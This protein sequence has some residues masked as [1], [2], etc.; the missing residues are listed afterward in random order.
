MKLGKK[1]WSGWEVL[2]IGV[3]GGEKGEGESNPNTLWNY[4][5]RKLINEKAK[6]I[7]INT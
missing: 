4:Q 2:L 7:L 5:A 6:Q 1:D 3:G